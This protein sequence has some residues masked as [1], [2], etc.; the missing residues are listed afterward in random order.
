MEDDDPPDQSGQEQQSMIYH[1]KYQK[2][3]KA[4]PDITQPNI[5]QPVNSTKTDYLVSKDLFVTIY[6]TLKE[7]DKDR[8]IEHQAFKFSSLETVKD[9]YFLIPHDLYEN[10]LQTL[11]EKVIN[12][13]NNPVFSD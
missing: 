2:I 9:G 10:F 6:S 1:I 3:V 7:E 13:I 11:K 5:Y 4:P 12:A 8:L